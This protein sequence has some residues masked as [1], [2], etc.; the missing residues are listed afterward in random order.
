[1]PRVTYGNEVED[2][3]L[4]IKDKLQESR[5]QEN[6][7]PT[8][9]TAVKLLEGDKE[10]EKLIEQ[11]YGRN[12]V[13]DQVRRSRS[14]L[15]EVFGDS[16]DIAVA[17]G[18]YGFIAGAVKETVTVDRIDRV[19][20]SDKI[21]NVLTHRLLGPVIMLIVLYGIYQFTFSGSE[22]L[23]KYFEGF[24]AWLGDFV[25]GIMPEGLLRSLV[26]SGIIEGVGGVL[27]F[28]PLIAFMFFAIAILEDTGYMAR[29]AFM[30]DR[31]LKVF[32]LHGSA[33]LALIVSGGIAGGC[34]VPGIMATRTLREPKERLTT[35]LV[36]PLMN[37][38]AKLPVYALLIAAFFPGD[39]ASMMFGLTLISWAMVLISAKV[40]R[41]TLLSGQTAPFVLEMP[42][43]RVPTLKGL[44]IHSWERTW[45]YI[46]KA[47]TVIL[48][49]AVVLWAMMT[50]P[51]LPDNLANEYDQRAAN[52]TSSFLSLPSVQ[53]TFKSDKD[54]AEFEEFRT[55][56][57]KE[58]P[59]TLRKENQAF[60]DLAK[61][62]SPKEPK[63]RPVNPEAQ[64]IQ[65]LAADYSSFSEKK[66]VVEMEK[67][68]TAI[69]NTI[70]GRIGVALEYVFKP[71]NFDWRTNIALVGGFAAKEVVVSTLGTAFSIG[72]VDPEESESLSEQLAKEP[73]WNALTAFT[74]IIF[75][76]LYAP[77]FVT[78]V[79]IR[80][81][82]GGW[83]WPAFA[84]VYTTA[85]AYVVALSVHTVGSFLG[86]GT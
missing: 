13:L 14:H 50:F 15:T 52:L 22:P 30:L 57:S 46:K 80:K 34:A 78:L 5:I 19:Y 25:T 60:F 37:C 72:K 66:D 26:V 41:S 49:V 77:C 32:G 8:H 29:V 39:K 54:I 44:L 63:D 33:I 23:V 20:L 6:G 83:K 61:T 9:W 7:L 70:G 86:L 38:G 73:G 84:M 67:Q 1:M 4:K 56:F 42:P 11:R 62:L 2:E 31:V 27:V 74:L 18:R 35:I 76:M 71:M 79:V 51:R 28:V 21:D 45:M 75:V 48:A 12:G 36:A 16:A 64:S 47:A 10:L 82:T 55:K 81:E 65:L 43:Y 40:L 17:D 59:D 58:T 85:L 3:L 53:G 24:F 69:R 68:S